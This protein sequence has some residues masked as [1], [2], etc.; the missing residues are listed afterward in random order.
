M[1]EFV[2]AFSS[3]STAS[4]ESLAFLATSR[5]EGTRISCHGNF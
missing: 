5:A 3:T 4:L 2:K 1:L